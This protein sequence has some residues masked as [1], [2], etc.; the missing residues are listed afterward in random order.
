MNFKRSEGREKRERERL[1]KKNPHAMLYYAHAQWPNPSKP[2]KI[3]AATRKFAV[4]CCPRDEFLARSRGRS[5]Q[6]CN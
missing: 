1:I 4:G 6:T 3:L 5:I 2:P